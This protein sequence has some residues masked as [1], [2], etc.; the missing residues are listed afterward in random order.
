M[1]D[2]IEKLKYIGA[3][4]DAVCWAGKQ[5][6]YEEMWANCERADWM[7]WLLGRASGSPHSEGRR[8]VVACAIDCAETALAYVKSDEPRAR[9]A[10][11]LA[12]LRSYTSTGDLQTFATARQKL[13]AAYAADYAAYAAACAAAYA[14]DY[15][16]DYAAAYAADYA[17]CAAAA[18]NKALKEMCTIVRRHF[19]QPP[20]I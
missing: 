11:G 12:L 13:A 15:A 4:S 18:R 1:R 5:P 19:Q 2:Y 14:A 20:V 10:H 3:C 7:L 8:K 6:S 16:A 17:A 9:L